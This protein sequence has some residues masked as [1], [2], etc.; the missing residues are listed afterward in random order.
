MFE[1]EISERKRTGKQDLK[2]LRAEG[3]IPAVIYGRK[4]ESTPIKLSK[5]N[6]VTVLKTA[7][8]SSII[9][10]KGLKDDKE[11]LVHD[12]DYD[13]ITSEPRHVDFYAIEKGKKLT[14]K[15]PLEF[16]GV[17]PAVKELNGILVKV[18]H[19]LEIE[20]L[21]KDLPQHIEVDIAPIVDFDTSLHVKDITLP[22][23]VVAITG[24]DE[25]VALASVAVE[26]VF[27]DETETP[28]LESIEVE[29][30]GKEEGE[31]VA[32]EGDAPPKV[33]SD[34]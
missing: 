20:V 8:E 21:P 9:S 16:V 29:K 17:S 33:E 28:D 34:N 24:D 25:V 18:L 12:V 13:P 31:E 15:V 22:E 26:E 1:L 11:A 5:K 6:F 7:G 19:E 10:L 14:M 32:P 27:E 2:S 4:E 23:G 3:F 30:K